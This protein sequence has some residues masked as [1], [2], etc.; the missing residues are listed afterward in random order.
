MVPINKNRDS[1]GEYKISGVKIWESPG[2]SNIQGSI[3][4]INKKTP[5][6]VHFLLTGIELQSWSCGGI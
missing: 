3:H 2:L 5:F 4:S 1:D 6:L